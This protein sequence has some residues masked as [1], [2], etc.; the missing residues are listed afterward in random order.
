MRVITA[1]DRVWPLVGM[2]RPWVFMAGG[3]TDCPNWQ[4][5]I[6]DKMTGKKGVLFNP[7]RDKFP[8]K[9]PNAAK[10]QIT[11]EY[12][13]LMSCHIF[14]VWFTG[15][16]SLQPIAQYELGRYLARYQ[17]GRLP[18]IVIGCDEGYKRRFDV[19]MQ[20]KLVDSNLHVYRSFEGYVSAVKEAIEEY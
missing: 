9:D 6:I 18:K 19:L 7:R 3:I 15:G 17:L 8:I 16:P 5:T 13:A 10:E 2:E 12:N 4:A 14:T 20:V 11:W 1:P